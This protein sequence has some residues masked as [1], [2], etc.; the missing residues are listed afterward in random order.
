MLIVVT[1][2]GIECAYWCD[3]GWNR[4][5]LLVGIGRAYWCVLKKKRSILYIFLVICPWE[6]RSEVMV[7]FWV[8][9]FCVELFRD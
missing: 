4:A 7:R 5:Y 3:Y 1:R 6:G 2:G 8:A 9:I